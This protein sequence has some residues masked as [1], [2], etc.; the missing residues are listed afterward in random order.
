MLDTCSTV[1]AVEHHAEAGTVLRRPGAGSLS[2]ETRWTRGRLG[3]RCLSLSRSGRSGPGHRDQ[4]S[5]SGS[6]PSGVLRAPVEPMT[7]C[8]TK[9]VF[10][11]F[12]Y[13]E[14][15]CPVLA[16]TLEPPGFAAILCGSDGVSVIPG[17]QSVDRFRPKLVIGRPVCDLWCGHSAPRDP[18]KLCAHSRRSRRTRHVPIPDVRPQQP[19]ANPISPAKSV[20]LTQE[21]GL[22]WTPRQTKSGN[23]LPLYSVAMPQIR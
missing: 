12:R 19:K 17:V 16:P 4:V 1:R 14:G 15:S 23:R 11:N 20:S 13:V 9:S 7:G 5:H 18:D 3:I 6:A 21:D 22:T 10:P 8:G 2:P